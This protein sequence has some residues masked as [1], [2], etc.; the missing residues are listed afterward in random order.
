[1]QF[2]YQALKSTVS[3][4]H[5]LVT[6]I[7]KALKYKEVALSSFVDI[8]GAFDNTGFES[9]TAA[10]V[11]KQIVP[12]LVEWIIGML[13][14]RIVTAGLGE[15]QVTVKNQRLPPRGVLSLLLWSLVIDKLLN[16]LNRQGFEVIGFADDLKL[17]HR[18]VETERF[19]HQPRKNNCHTIH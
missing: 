19:K 1:M 8:Q 12:E 18:V 17:H 10:A 5:H 6:K 2:A 7:E 15:E 3:A 14:C 9:I 4:L 11:S 16:D 13:E